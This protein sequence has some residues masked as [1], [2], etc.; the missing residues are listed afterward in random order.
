MVQFA[1]FGTSYVE[2]HRIYII[3]HLCLVYSI[4]F[5][6]CIN[7]HSSLVCFHAVS[8][9]VTTPQVGHSHWLF[10]HCCEHLPTFPGAHGSLGFLSR[11]EDWLEDNACSWSLEG[12]GGVC[13]SPA[14]ERT[15]QAEETECA[16]AQR[17]EPHDILGEVTSSIIGVWPLD[18]SKWGPQFEQVVKCYSAHLFN[19]WG[20]G[21]ILSYCL[22]SAGHGV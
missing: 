19:L 21:Y 11:G 10:T 13:K 2:S 17:C 18:S 7:V 15:F 22:H 6:S 9:C 4:V 3:F 5:I 16:K 20:D 12:S 1:C 14:R 8:H